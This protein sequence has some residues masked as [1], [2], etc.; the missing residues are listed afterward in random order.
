MTFSV[1]FYDEASKSWGVGVASKFLAVGS[2]VPWAKAG[3]GAVATQAYVNYS[4]G[5]GGMELLKSHDAKATLDSLTSSD[6]LKERRQA[7]IVDRKGN[8]A[9]FT[10]SG[11]HDYAGHVMGDGFSV[12]GNILAGEEV[13]EAMAREM[14]RNGPILERVLRALEAADAKGGDRRGK[15]SA[16]VLIATE[17]TGFEE[18]SDIYIDLRVDDSTEPIEE[19]IRMSRLW[20][21]TFFDQ[22]MVEIGPHRD[23]IDIALKKAGYSSLQEWGANNNFTSKITEDRIAVRVLDVLLSGARKSW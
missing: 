16:A 17:G 5:P 12:Q 1:V 23:E 3:V 11:C 13:I 18:H 14:E 19:L 22:E 9:A 6:S 4:Y 10:G 7:A 2:V 21:A 8:V 15:Q 20:E